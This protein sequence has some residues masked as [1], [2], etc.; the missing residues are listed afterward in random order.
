MG[1]KTLL[2]QLSVTGESRVTP[3][4]CIVSE[5][6]KGTSTGRGRGRGRGTGT[7]RGKDGGDLL[8]PKAYDK[9]L[10]GRRRDKKNCIATGEKRRE[11]SR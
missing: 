7:G 4:P 3:W 6:G 8:L 1:G 2:Y 5:P 10:G 11:D 9:A